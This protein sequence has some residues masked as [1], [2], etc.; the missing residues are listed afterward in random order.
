M[1]FFITRYVL[2]NGIQEIEAEECGNGMLRTPRIANEIVKY[3]HGE[4]KDWHKTLENARVRAEEIRKKKIVSLNKSI[5]KLE[6]MK[7]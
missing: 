2:T 7:F 3:F 5:K 6:Q 4:G 1:K